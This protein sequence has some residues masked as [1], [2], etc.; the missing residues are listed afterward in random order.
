MASHMLVDQEADSMEAEAVLGY[1]LQGPPFNNQP[2]TVWPNN[3]QNSSMCQRLDVQ[4][5]IKT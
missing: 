3:L 5:R 1:N 2:P 4:T